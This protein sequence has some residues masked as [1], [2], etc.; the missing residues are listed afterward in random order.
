MRLRSAL[1]ELSV[2]AMGTVTKILIFFLDLCTPGA[3]IE[4]M[5]KHDL[6]TVRKFQ[7]VLRSTGAHHDVFKIISL[8]LLTEV[9]LRAIHSR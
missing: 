7:D 3:H 4:D 2:E 5:Q 1:Q 8:P 6:T 9:C